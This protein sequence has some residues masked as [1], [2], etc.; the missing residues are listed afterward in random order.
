MA[1]PW[2]KNLIKIP[3][4]IKERVSKLGT[5]NMVV[6]CSLKI[7]TEDILN[8]VYQHLN[9]R[10]VDGKLECPA[11]ILPSPD[12]GRYSK[13]NLYGHEVVHRDEPML[14]KTY[15]VESPNYGDWDKG[16]HEVSWSRDVYRRGFLSPKYLEIII[17]FLGIDNKNNH[18]FKFTVDDVLNINL[19]NY[20]DNLLFD[21]NLLQ[22]NV[23]N[24]GVFPTDADINDYL[25]S[26]YVNWEILPPGEI[27]ENITRIL[28][29]VKSTDPKL[30]QRITDR[31]KFLLA[32]KPQNIIQG[33]SRFQRYFGAKFAD[34]LV[35]FENVEY[36]NAIYVMFENWEELSQR[37]RTELLSSDTQNFIRV[38]HTKTWKLVLRAIVNKELRKRKAKPTVH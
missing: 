16:S 35:V 18:V 9:I 12:S 36:G 22:E 37:S 27:E 24:H 5:S 2:K 6:A 13:Y 11:R 17:E 33:T 15:S 32:L 3:D 1:Q 7:K 19:P 25:K 31:Y 4:S 21:L 10:I 34:D 38:R 29:G 23:G 26:L 30:R 28:T 14:S 8:G 20:W